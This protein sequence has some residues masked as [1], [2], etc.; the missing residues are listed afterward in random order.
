MSILG[1]I[2]KNTWLLFLFVGIFLLVFILDPNLLKIFYENPNIIGKVNGE[3]IPVKE[4]INCFQF[5]KLF[6]QDEPDIYLKNEA[7]KLL[8]HEK[9]LNQQAVKLGIQSTKKEFWDAVSKQS[10]Y[11]NISDFQNFNGELDI[12]KFQSYLK[13][14]ENTSPISNPRI[15]EEKNIWLYEKKNIAKKIFAK[16][17][18]EMLMYGLNTSLIEAELNYK[19]KNFFS[20]ID[21]I[22]IPYSEIENRY[23]NMFSINNY[24][25]SDYIKKHKFFYNKKKENLRSLSFVIFR[26]KP[27]LDDENYMRKKMENLFYKFQST[28]KNS[29]FVSN[30]SEKPFD[31]NFYLK[32]SLPPILQNFV[33]NNNN[34][35]GSI[36]GPIKEKNIYMMAKLTGK[37]MISDSVLV[38]HI[39]I[40]HKNAARSS[41][42]RTK[43]VSKKIAQN[44][45][46][47]LK[48]NPSLFDFFVKKKSDDLMNAK[49]NKGSLGWIKYE[50]KNSIG[51]FDIFSSKNKKGMIGMTETKFGYHILRID[52]KSSFIPSYQFAVIIK[53]LI[54]SKKTE[55]F[56]YKRVRKFLIK[57]KNSSLNT[58][59]N[60]A[61]R[62]KYETI[63]LKNIK[64]SQWEI[65]GLN[66]EVDKEII[67][68]A[69]EKNRKK[70]DFKMLSTSNNK[71][72][73]LIY[74]S[75]IQN[76]GISIEKIKKDL[77]FSLKKE[78]IS[79]YLSNMMNKK[80]FPKNLKEIAFYFSK[81]I[82]KYYKIN[83]HDSIIDSCKEPEVVGYSFSLKLGETSPP[84]LGEKGVFFVRPLKHFFPSK[85][86]SYFSY[87]ME[88]LNSYLRKNSLEILGKVFMDKSIIKDYRSNILD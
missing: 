69:F 64:S 32:R 3:N 53:T 62:N 57:N 36:F 86:P 19:D 49:K 37:K 34:K 29:I 18:I 52:D 43:E 28:N 83:F 65:D 26:S 59:I 33:S 6:R 51:E 25:I 22:F 84:I 38:S 35:I 54:P 50:D 12:V 85:K 70:G 27:S 23:K 40:S 46:N 45:Y 61:R 1:K 44:I 58:L 7:W 63:Y 11:S 78:K 31:S 76:R 5:L 68:W 15:E 72:Y 71:D 20:F 88:I 14:L 80:F 67:N 47:I 82:K 21:Y 42:Q 16:K 74:L 79:R 87:E 30:Q 17:Y 9:M 55:D 24:E 56:L 41:N 13:K 66:T 81:K 8:I 4:Y 2:R 77:I 73:I 39:L 10:L 75:K 48:K 60:N